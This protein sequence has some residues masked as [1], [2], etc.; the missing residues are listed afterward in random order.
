MR[1]PQVSN[2]TLIVT[3]GAAALMVAAVT[4]VKKTQITPEPPA[5]I[6]FV[7]TA[8]AP[9]SESPKPVKPKDASTT[10]LELFSP[11][12]KALTNQINETTISQQIEQIMAT[13]FVLTNCNIISGE[14]Y[15]RTY[16]ASIAY[17]LQTKLAHSQKEAVAKVYSITKSAGAS[18]GLIYSRTKCDD[19]KLPTAAQQLKTWVAGYL[20]ND[21][22]AARFEAD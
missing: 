11:S 7:L 20:P 9:T 19:A 10:V 2:R 8:E 13:S 15:K 18:Y 5:P 6:P 12:D 21:P 22:R 16:Q 17:A 3:A 14:D 4:Y 1:L